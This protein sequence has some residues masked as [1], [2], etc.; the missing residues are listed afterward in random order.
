MDRQR[1]MRIAGFLCTA[2]VLFGACAAVAE[3]VAEGPYWGVIDKYCVECHNAIDWSGGVAFDVIED[4][5]T[6]A[7]V[8]RLQSHRQESQARECE[9][10]NAVCDGRGT[11]G[12]SPATSLAVHWLALQRT[13]AS[14]PRDRAGPVWFRIRNSPLRGF[15]S[16]EAL[17]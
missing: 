9:P 14:S 4:R 6:H 17:R 2:A 3:T 7:F 16:D 8:T 12:R 5:T 15:S 13:E 11:S 10:L 1:Q